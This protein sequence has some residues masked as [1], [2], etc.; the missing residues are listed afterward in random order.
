MLFWPAEKKKEAPQPFASAISEDGAMLKSKSSAHHQLWYKSSTGKGGGR[1]PGSIFQSIGLGPLQGCS[2]RSFSS[3]WPVLMS[4]AS[5]FPALPLGFGQCISP[6]GRCPASPYIQ[7]KTFP[8]SVSLR[9]AVPSSDALFEVKDS[10]KPNS[11]RGSAGKGR[12]TMEG[13]GCL[14]TTRSGVGHGPPLPP[15]LHR[16]QVRATGLTRVI[17]GKGETRICLGWL[18]GVDPGLGLDVTSLRGSLPAPPAGML[19]L[20]LH[21]RAARCPFTAG[22]DGMLPTRIF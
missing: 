10:S 2:R 22:P 3:F 14:L 9:K 12:H 6:L 21:T 7:L 20:A 19:R 5:G 15:R 8:I 17:L 13:C 16:C 4:R 18:V 11:R 1:K